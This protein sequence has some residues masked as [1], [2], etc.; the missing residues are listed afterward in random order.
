MYMIPV[1]IK[2]VESLLQ[3]SIDF[4]YEP[5][6]HST[7]ILKNHPAVGTRVAICASPLGLPS[8]KKTTTLSDSRTNPWFRTR[9]SHVKKENRP[10][11]HIYPIPPFNSLWEYL[12]ATF[13]YDVIRLV[14][15]CGCFTL[16]DMTVY[17]CLL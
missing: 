2:A 17:V 9:P 3:R 15:V 16:V 1:G 10:D 5:S 7:Y 13:P 8:H 11:N 14:C 4:P 6:L 12:L